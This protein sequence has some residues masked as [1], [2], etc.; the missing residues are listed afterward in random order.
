LSKLGKEDLY[1]IL[2]RQ[3]LTMVLQPGESL[4]EVSLV[5]Q[6]KLS[7]TPVREVLRQMAGEG[8]LEITKNRGARV[9]P[10]S[11]KM[12]RDF[13]RTAPPIYASIAALAAENRT[14]K[15]LSDLKAAQACFCE[16][17]KKSDAELMAYHNNDFHLIIG[18]MADN[19]YLWPSLQRL[20]ID[21]ARIAHT[22][23]RV[24]DKGMEG[25]LNTARDHHDQFIDAIEQRNA[26]KAKQLALDH[27]DL[28]RDHIELFVRPDPLNIDLDVA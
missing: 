2:K 19:Q 26:V 6:Y 27:W 25:R 15:Q 10:M 14:L 4:D 7:R 22:F 20:S 12:L 23:Y 18:E 21:H 5:A 16:A 17:V 8:Y 13:F 11:Y 24:S 28:S 3:V 9:S 1:Q